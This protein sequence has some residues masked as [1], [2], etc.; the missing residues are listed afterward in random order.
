ME[1]LRA[2]VLIGV[3]RG[4]LQRQ[5]VTGAICVIAEGAPQKLIYS[6]VYSFAILRNRFNSL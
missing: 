2:S 6:E 1:R 3:P 5:N 4:M